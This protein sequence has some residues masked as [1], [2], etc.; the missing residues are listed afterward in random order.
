MKKEINPEHKGTIIIDSIT[1]II[2]ELGYRNLE[3]VKTGLGENAFEVRAM[4]NREETLK[5]FQKDLENI[6]IASK[7]VEDE[8]TFGDHRLKIDS[9]QMVSGDPLYAEGGRVRRT[10]SEMQKARYNAEVEKYRWFVVEPSIKKVHSGFEYKEDAQELL[11]DFEK[12]QCKVIAKVSLEKQGYKNPIEEW[13]SMAKGGMIKSEWKS[14]VTKFLNEFFGDYESSTAKDYEDKNSITSD[15]TKSKPSGHC[16]ITGLYSKYE[17][18][19]TF[20]EAYNA[21]YSALTPKERKLIKISNDSGEFADAEEHDQVKDWESITITK[22]DNASK[23]KKEKELSFT[24]L[25]KQIEST[26]SH[27]APDFSLNDWEEDGSYFSLSSRAYGSVS[28]GEPGEEDFEAANELKKALD[29][30]FGNDYEQEVEHS[31]EW[32]SVAM[33]KIDKSAKKDNTMKDTISKENKWKGDVYFNVQLQG[34]MPYSDAQGVADG[35]EMTNGSLTKYFEQGLS[36]EKAATLILS[37][38]KESKPATKPIYSKGDL[39]DASEI[40][41]NQGDKKGQVQYTAKS[42][43]E[44]VDLQHSSSYGWVYGAVKDGVYH[45]VAESQIKKHTPSSDP[46]PE[47]TKQLTAMAKKHATVICSEVPDE[48]KKEFQ[49]I[50]HHTKDFTVN[51]EKFQKNYDDLY[52]ALKSQFP[53]AIKAASMDIKKVENK[54]KGLRVL[55]GRLSGEKLAK[56]E[57]K[58]KGLE[59]VAKRHGSKKTPAPAKSSNTEKSKEEL[60]EA[61][62][63]IVE[64]WHLIA[65]DTNKRPKTRIGYIDNIKMS[66]AFGVV[67]EYS[68]ETSDPYVGIL[69]K[70][71]KD[72]IEAVYNAVSKY[73]ND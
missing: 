9:I 68:T 73:K 21:F 42:G 56:I 40:K 67:F 70:Q 43:L 28:E 31:D 7:Y 16:P 52:N 33:R 48:I 69:K 24:E 5:K 38:E 37:P 46:K 27:I 50:K 3:V 4:N 53:K 41:F 63:K 29:K 11:E 59:I 10:K 20:E 60:I 22:V 65:F 71:D 30:E 39:V 47:A 35:A 15:Q 12:G 51:T 72:I 18:E 2:D 34:E 62:K 14:I 66:K 45:N 58:I 1:Y 26:A 44:I 61:T 6:G 17:R 32:V 25:K 57:R 13:K 36:P 23:G 19:P 64:K 49:L 55:K 54:L 8:S